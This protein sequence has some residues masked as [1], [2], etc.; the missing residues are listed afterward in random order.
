MSLPHFDT[1]PIEGRASSFPQQ[2]HLWTQMIGAA[3]PDHHASINAAVSTP[4]GSTETIKEREAHSAKWVVT[5]VDAVR[6]NRLTPDIVF[7]EIRQLGSDDSP[8]E[9]LNK[10]A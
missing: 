5:Y 4:A 8:L 10:H 6:S 2:A 3:H 7:G 1:T 9:I